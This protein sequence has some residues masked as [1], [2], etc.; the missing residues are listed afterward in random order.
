MKFRNPETGE[1]FDVTN[2]APRTGFCSGIRC[3]ECPIGK[4]PHCKEFINHFPHEAA[5]LMDYEVAYEPGDD[6]VSLNML[7]DTFNEIGKEADMDKLRICEVLGVE[8]GE[9]WEYGGLEYSV[10][11]KGL[12]V[13]HNNFVYFA[14]LTGIINHPEHIIR[15]PRFTQQ[16]VEDAKMVKAVFGKNGIIKRYDK[17]TTEPYS[18]LVF[19]NIYINENMFPSIKEGQEYSLDEIIGSGE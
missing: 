5:R 1:I 3:Y 11:E 10:T 14:G 8:V 4:G 18:T 6:A 7:S 17:A 16:E 19:N 13:D 9:W 15:K 12:I 2:G